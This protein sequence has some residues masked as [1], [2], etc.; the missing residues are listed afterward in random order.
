MA[1]VS[2]LFVAEASMKPMVSK[3]A[4]DLV[5][6][7]GISGDR[8]AEG[9]GTYQPFK[10]PGRQLTLISADTIE[11]LTVGKL[12]APSVAN[13]R[14]NVV[15]RGISA[16]ELESYI[17]MEVRLG[18]E[19]RVFVHRLCVPCKY[20]M[21]LNKCAIDME[22]YLWQATGVNCEVD[23]KPMPPCHHLKIIST[24]PR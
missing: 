20:N 23:S 17:G 13:L 1:R 12:H 3:D 14:R 16:A 19:C 9:L 18:K 24:F 22:E 5:A 15:L 21:R 10:E 2:G 11:E 8:Y 7:K 4:V 6:G